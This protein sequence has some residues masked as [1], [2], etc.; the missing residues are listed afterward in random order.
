MADAMKAARFNRLYFAGPI[1]GAPGK[2]IKMTDEEFAKINAQCGEGTVEW[3][4]DLE[5][6]KE[7]TPVRA[8]AV[9]G[10]PPP[11]GADKSIKPKQVTAKAGDKTDG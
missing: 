2:I 9:P 10:A 11:G 5:K 4:T 1:Q 3:V 8:G 7:E 6:K